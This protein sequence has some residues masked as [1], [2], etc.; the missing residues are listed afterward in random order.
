MSAWLGGFYADQFV[1]LLNNLRKSA[2]ARADFFPRETS[3]YS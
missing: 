1:C 3:T 2:I